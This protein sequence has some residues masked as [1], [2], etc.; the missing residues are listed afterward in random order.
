MKKTITMYVEGGKKFSE[1]LNMTA[2]FEQIF[3]LGKDKQ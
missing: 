3:C 1:M 2:S